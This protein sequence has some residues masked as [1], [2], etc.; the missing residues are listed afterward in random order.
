MSLFK[1]EVGRHSNETL[2]KRKIVIA[3]IIAVI[4]LL[5]GGVS[6]LVVRRLGNIDGSSKNA[7][8]GKFTVTQQEKNCYKVEAPLNEKYWAVHVYYKD[9]STGY[10]QKAL[11]KKYFDYNNNS[12]RPL[13]NDLHTQQTHRRQSPP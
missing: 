6:F 12:S 3:S 10:F 1:N 5:I 13:I 4:I 9:P 8:A 7:V 11:I 2:K